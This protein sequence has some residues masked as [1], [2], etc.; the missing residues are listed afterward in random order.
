L[1]LIFDRASLKEI[2]IERLLGSYDIQVRIVY[3]ATHPAAVA[4]AIIRALLWG[5]SMFSVSTNAKQMDAGV[6]DFLK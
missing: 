5:R 1:P 6:T 2:T 4:E 3:E